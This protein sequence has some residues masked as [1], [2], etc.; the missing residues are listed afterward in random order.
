MNHNRSI[1][2]IS[3]SIDVP[4]GRRQSFKKA[5]EDDAETPDVYYLH[6]TRKAR[7]HSLPLVEQLRR[8]GISVLQR[9]TKDR[10][11][12]QI[13]IAKRMG[14]KH[15]VIMG[16]QE[17]RDNTVIVRNMQDRSQETIRADRLSQFL[18]KV[19]L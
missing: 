2:T 17:V 11:R 14:V 16:L 3:A 5:D 15:A 1:G 12:D 19:A 6:L 18:K 10:L 8:E 9:L 7:K 4:G 13:A